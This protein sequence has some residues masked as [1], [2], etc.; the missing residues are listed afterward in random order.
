MEL[1]T[2]CPESD[3]ETR[4][5]A[6]E[7]DDVRF[8]LTEKSPGVCLLKEEEGDAEDS[9]AV[10]NPATL[11]ASICIA[12]YAQP[13]FDLATVEAPQPPENR[14]LVLCL[15]CKYSQ[16]ANSNEDMQQTVS[17]KRRL[18]QEQVKTWMKDA[19]FG[20]CMHGCFGGR[21]DVSWCTNDVVLAARAQPGE[22]KNGHFRLVFIILR[23]PDGPLPAMG[24][25]VLVLTREHL[26]KL[27]GPSLARLPQFMADNKHGRASR[28]V[29]PSSIVGAT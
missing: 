21:L 3:L 14:P 28:A 6:P 16:E 29:S 12:P 9:T 15:E 5:E 10:T 1:Y 27:Y 8:A 23:H 25:D 22:L 2:A 13:G 26:L 19:K 4:P 17:H 7:F 24:K 11:R 18:W 20:T